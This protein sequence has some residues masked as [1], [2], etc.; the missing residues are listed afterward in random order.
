M[1]GLKRLNPRPD[2]T[3]YLLFLENPSSA[4]TL[5]GVFDSPR[6]ALQFLRPILNNVSWTEGE[7]WLEREWVYSKTGSAFYYLPT[8]VLHLGDLFSPPKEVR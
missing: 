5:L 4:D 8:T 1:N 6:A 7:G 3:V 2:A